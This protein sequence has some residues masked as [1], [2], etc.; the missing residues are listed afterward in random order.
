LSNNNKI[1]LLIEIFSEV[2]KM[3]E[4]IVEYALKLKEN[5]PIIKAEKSA[6]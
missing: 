3:I 2:T 4:N 1:I 6:E 5:K